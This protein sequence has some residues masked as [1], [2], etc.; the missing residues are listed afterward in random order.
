MTASINTEFNAVSDTYDGT[1]VIDPFPLYAELSAA[2]PVMDGDILA[3]FGVPSQADY[4]NK[5]RRV[6]TLF[7]ND[8]LKMWSRLGESKAEFLLR[9]DTEAEARADDETNELRAT[10]EAKKDRIQQTID[11]AQQ[12]AEEVRE[13]A[14]DDK[15]NE[16]IA[17]AGAVLGALFGG[18]KSARSIARSVTSASSR[19]ARSSKAD[20]RADTAQARVEAKMDELAAL[21]QQLSDEVFDIDAKWDTVGKTIK[22][23]PVTLERA[24]IT[25]SELAICWIPTA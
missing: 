19:R 9:C 22:E 16:L 11:L 1:G 3:R 10:L 4:G 20:N 18:R 25:V 24:D 5:G 17:G 15:K 14:K 13:N 6:F 23:V 21:E 7:R 8:A 12:K 2:T